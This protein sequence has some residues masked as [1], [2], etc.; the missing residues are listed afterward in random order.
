MAKITININPDDYRAFELIVPDPGQWVADAVHNKIRK[1][2]I[3]VAEE[4]SRDSLFED[5]SLLAITE[6]VKDDESVL[7]APKHYSKKIKR[8]IAK[9]T[10]MKTRKERDKEL[11]DG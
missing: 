9:R 1:C 8:E 6:M 11:T 5:S 4:A 10:T 2:L 3:R 7:K